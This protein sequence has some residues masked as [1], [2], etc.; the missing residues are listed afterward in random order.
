[1]RKLL[2]VMALIIPVAAHAACPTCNC[3]EDED[4]DDGV[5]H[6]YSYIGLKG[7]THHLAE[8]MLLTNSSKGYGLYFGARH[9]KLFGV[10]G[11]YTYVGSFLAPTGTGHINAVSL[12]GI[13][14][15][16]IGWA[17]LIGKLGIARTITPLQN[18]TNAQVEL[19][20]G[21]GMEFSL[22]H[23]LLLRFGYDRYKVSLT[24]KRPDDYAHIGV[25]YKF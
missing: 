7:G 15:V 1:M 19:F 4:E 23:D 10:E 20:Y 11:E 25:A 17:D 16:D 14:Y 5:Y 9:S 18:A 8:P 13:H 3:N 21:V 22:T 2:L 6:G 12:A 24:E